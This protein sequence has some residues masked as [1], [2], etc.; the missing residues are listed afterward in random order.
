M[1]IVLILLLSLTLFRGAFALDTVRGTV[2]DVREGD[3]L[4][5]STGDK[6]HRVRL[7]EIDAP[8]KGQRF[9][10][11]SIETLSK[12]ALGKP[13]EVIVIGKNTRGRLLGRVF[14]GQLDVNAEMVRLGFAWVDLKTIRDPVLIELEK[15][16]R[17]EKRGL[18]QNPYPIPPWEW[19]RGKR[20]AQRPSGRPILAAH[21]YKY[22]YECNWLL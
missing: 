14:A 18:W 6:T 2:S 3:V 12:L 21:S 8:E 1:R 20:R 16:A 22:W 17:R 4:M 9:A 13:I 19:R 7:A 11:E 10:R 15:I 5:L